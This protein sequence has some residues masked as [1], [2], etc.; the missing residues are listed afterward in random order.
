MQTEAVTKVY[1]QDSTRFPV[2]SHSVIKNLI[3]SG[4]TVLDVGCAAGQLGKVCSGND[5]Y[6]IDGNKEALSQAQPLYKQTALMNLNEV[7]TTPVFETKFDYIVF[8]DVLEHLL[9]PE[10]ILAHFKNYLKPGGCVI[11]SLPNVA[12]WRVRLNLL[13]GKFDYSDYGVMDRTHLHLYTFKTAREML[14]K[15]GFTVVKVQGATYSF[16]NWINS[17][18]TVRD[19]LSVHVICLAK[20]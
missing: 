5:F 12:L 9:Y 17:I 20:I 2:G 8:A 18:T 13:L 7:P 14:E 4:K 6:G 10:Q 1:T 11:V 3:G 15:C 16:G 19:L